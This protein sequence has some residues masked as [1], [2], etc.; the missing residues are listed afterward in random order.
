MLP[1]LAGG[2]PADAHRPET[3][4]A[5][6]PLIVERAL[7]GIGG[8]ETVRDLHQD[9][10]FSMVALTAA[11]LTGTETKV[12]AK[13]PDGSW[14]QWYDAEALDGVGDDNTKTGTEP[15]FVGRTTDVQISV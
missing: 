3:P 1:F 8:G 14:G 13:K 7:T 9:T 6:A 4:L 2:L 12:R 15:V 5:T 10:P 11:D